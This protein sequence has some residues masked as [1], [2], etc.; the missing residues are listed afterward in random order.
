[1]SSFGVW[2]TSPI[3][4]GV[5]AAEDTRAISPS[6]HVTLYAEG[7]K[8]LELLYSVLKRDL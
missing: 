3:R 2:N 5:C 8:Q 6:K 4:N 1:M 7:M